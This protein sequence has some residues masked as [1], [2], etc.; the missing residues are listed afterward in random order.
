MPVE[1]A[2]EFEDMNIVQNEDNMFNQDINNQLEDESNY[3]PAQRMNFGTSKKL[4]DVVSQVENHP[5]H[6]APVPG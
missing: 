1:S 2:H 4:L 6:L 3:P 5:V